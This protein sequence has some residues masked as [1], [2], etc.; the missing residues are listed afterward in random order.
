MR[1]CRIGWRCE[2][3]RANAQPG[4]GFVE[5]AAEL[6]R[7]EYTKGSFDDALATVNGGLAVD[8][9]SAALAALKATIEQAK[10]KREIVLDELSDV[11]SGRVW[12]SSVRMRN[13]T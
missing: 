10:L 1:R 3:I 6:A 7:I 11:S 13:S 9:Q 12:R 5:A 4:P 8:P 2:S